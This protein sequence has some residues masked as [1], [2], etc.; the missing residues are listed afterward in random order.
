MVYETDTSK[1]SKDLDLV[2]EEKNINTDSLIDFI[3]YIKPPSLVNF[4]NPVLFRKHVAE[5]GKNKI[6][7]GNHVPTEKE[8]S[9]IDILKNDKENLYFHR[10]QND[11]NYLKNSFILCDI[12]LFVVK[13]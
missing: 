12:D 10:I 9:H 11:K 3:P 2:M 13:Y 4:R 6:N 8:T 5:V 7:V 1:I